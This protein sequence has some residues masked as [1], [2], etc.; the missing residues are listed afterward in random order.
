MISCVLLLFVVVKYQ[1]ELSIIMRLCY[2]TLTFTFYFLFSHCRQD[3]VPDRLAR[4]RG[5]WQGERLASFAGE[6]KCAAK[7]AAKSE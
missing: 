6:A 7:E 4:G 5:E 2:R 1:T 3:C